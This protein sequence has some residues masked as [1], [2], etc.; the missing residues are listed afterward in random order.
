MF[1]ILV[2]EHDWLRVGLAMLFILLFRTVQFPHESE[3]FKLRHHRGDFRAPPCLL[4]LLNYLLG[5]TKKISGF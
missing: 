4:R 1:G 5:P 2:Y 3:H